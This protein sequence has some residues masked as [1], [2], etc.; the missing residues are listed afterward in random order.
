ME[1]DSEHPSLSFR[2]D[3]RPSAAVINAVA[4]CNGTDPTTL[5]PLQ[6]VLDVDALD[7]L[8]DAPQEAA[9]SITFDYEGWTVQVA[10]DGTLTIRGSPHS[11]QV[12]PGQATTVLLLSPLGVL[13]MLRPATSC[14][15]RCH[16]PQ[17]TSSG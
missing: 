1:S 14:C 8:L 7:T 10:G 6:E 2:Y 16:R 17:H 4:W 9:V 15:H 5:T 11:M 13:T 12:K 3:E